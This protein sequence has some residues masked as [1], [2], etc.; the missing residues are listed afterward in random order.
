MRSALVGA[1]ALLLVACG[2]GSGTASQPATASAPAPSRTVRGPADL[3]TE[4]EIIS[5]GMNYE[6]ALEVV[7]S[8]RPAMLRP[9]AGA[10]AQ[11]VML[12][13]DDVRMNDMNGLSTVPTNRVRE[14]RFINARDATTRWG[15]GHDSGVILLTTK[16]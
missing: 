15:T 14:I 5:S 6:N 2:G 13:I 8:L 7:R 9:R 16:R 1:L 4:A 11:A 12:Y 3:I 10:G